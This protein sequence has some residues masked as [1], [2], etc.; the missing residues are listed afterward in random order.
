LQFKTA[1]NLND[2]Y[3]LEKTDNHFHD[4]TLLGNGTRIIDSDIVVPSNYNATFDRPGW[5]C[6]DGDNPY[7]SHRNKLIFVHIFKTAGSTFRSFFEQYGKKCGKGV[8][9]LIHCSQVSSAS[10]QSP[11][12]DEI[13]EP[14]C[15]V[16]KTLTRDKKIINEQGNVTWSHLQNHT[17]VVIGHFPLGLHTNWI[18]E[19]SEKLIEPLYIAFFRDPFAQFVSAQLFWNKTMNWTFDE[20]VEAIKWKVLEHNNHRQYVNFYQAYL[21]T[22]Q[23]K[24]V[25][26]ERAYSEQQWVEI[27]QQNIFGMHVLVGIVEQMRESVELI[28]SVIDVDRE[29][30]KQFRKLDAENMNIL[31][32]S[33]KLVKNRSNLSTSDI[34]AKLK[35]DDKFWN[36]FTDVVKYESH[37]YEFAREVHN[38]QY[39]HLKEHHGHR[40][41]LYPD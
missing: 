3:T 36:I 20:A 2:L 35:E 16:K 41:N 6:S 1:W 24:E 15:T 34:L 19:E 12:P 21:T 30:D 9:V 33:K 32:S 5:R 17:D 4:D 39:H 11:N 22:P 28:Q 27:I 31:V 23:Q 10:L 18:D 40:Y 13:W 25:G 7:A 14:D 29:L 8:S 26:R 37:L 38:H